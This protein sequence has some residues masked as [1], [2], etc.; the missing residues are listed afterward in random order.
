MRRRSELRGSQNN[1]ASRRVGGI[2][3]HRNVATANRS[4]TV[5]LVAIGAC[6]LEICHERSSK[7]R[8]LQVRPNVDIH[9]R[10]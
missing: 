1:P 7:Y 4:A 5:V 9:Q 6:A 10:L 2:F 3:S 8:H